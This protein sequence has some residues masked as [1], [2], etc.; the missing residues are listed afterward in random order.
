MPET[1]AIQAEL[2]QLSMLR[3]SL[4]DSHWFPG[5]SPRSGIDAQ[6]EVIRRNMTNAQIAAT[7]AN[8]GYYWCRAEE[9]RDWLDG[10]GKNPS[11][12]WAERM[13]S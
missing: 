10:C 6:C 1:N 8:N 11:Q 9:A 5:D 13:K 12:L 3:M 4:P 7:W 2:V